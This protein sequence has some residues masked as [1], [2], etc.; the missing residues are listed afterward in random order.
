MSK[1]EAFRLLRIGTAA[2]RREAARQLTSDVGP[3]DLQRLQNARQREAD[4]FV[5]AALEDTIKAAM[6]SLPDPP[7]LAAEPL[8]ADLA[9]DE[10]YARGFEEATLMVVHELGTSIGLV[11]SAAR[12]DIP[13]F[14]GSRTES[15]LERLSGL[16]E[17]V[18]RF[19][20][21][22]SAPNYEEFNLAGLVAD[23]AASISEQTGVETDPS[24][25]EPLMLVSDPSLIGF[26]V[27]NG[28][29]NACESVRETHP[30]AHNRPRVIVSWGGTDREA[31][32]SVLDR[33][34]GLPD[35]LPNPFAFGESRK[36]EDEHLG[37]GLALARRSVVTLG[38]TIILEPRD[39]GGAHFEIRWPHTE[40][41]V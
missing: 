41:R 12:S 7:D 13:E 29:K 8:D 21:T 33:G 3:E 15:R 32:V 40:D 39:G 25:Q 2:E 30:D 14:E 5:S 36:D 20:R 11:R 6:R 28:I 31:W 27:G 10:H 34:K 19:G 23:L 35:D 38:G 24:G 17:A 22:V 18:E 37:V 1:E 4:S 9:R 16:L 26:A